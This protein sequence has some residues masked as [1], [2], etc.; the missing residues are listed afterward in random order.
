MIQVDDVSILM[1]GNSPRAALILRAGTS[2]RIF[3]M[4]LQ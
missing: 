4:S 3:Y 2:S 1:E